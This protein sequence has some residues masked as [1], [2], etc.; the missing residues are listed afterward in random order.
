[1]LSFFLETRSPSLD[2]KKHAIRSMFRNLMRVLNYAIN[3]KFRMLI[4]ISYIRLKRQACCVQPAMT[5]GAL[6]QIPGQSPNKSTT[7][8]LSHT[9]MDR[10]TLNMAYKD[11][12]INI[13]GIERDRQR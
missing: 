4:L 12:R 2:I 5:Y 13:W 10:S 8:L 9:N 6:Q 3:L 7:D 1:M 11:S